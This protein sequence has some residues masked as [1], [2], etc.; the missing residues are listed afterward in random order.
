MNTVCCLVAVA[1]YLQCPK[2]NWR[3]C[4]TYV[5]YCTCQRL[6]WVCKL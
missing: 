3:K 5:S 4:V 2:E 1:R 6:N